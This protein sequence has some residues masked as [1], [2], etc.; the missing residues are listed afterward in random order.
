MT[1]VDGSQVPQAKRAVNELFAKEKVRSASDASWWEFCGRVEAR[2]E[3]LETLVQEQAAVIEELRDGKCRCGEPGS[4]DSPIEVL[5][6]EDVG[7][8]RASLEAVGSGSSYATPE[9]NPSPLP[10]VIRPLAQ[11]ISGSSQMSWAQ[12][13]A[14]LGSF[15]DPAE[16]RTCF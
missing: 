9:E 6:E 10:V 12:Y 11:R 3:A 8:G 2:L 16:P 4:R 1:D 7:E 5:D 15:E 13:D 14:Y